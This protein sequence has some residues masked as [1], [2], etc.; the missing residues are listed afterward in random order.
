MGFNI[1]IR[2][3][4]IQILNITNTWQWFPLF[5]VILSPISKR[6]RIPFQ[7][8]SGYRVLTD[9]GPHRKVIFVLLTI[10]VYRKIDG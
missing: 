9:L 5:F 6:I 8:E 7:K 4:K 2:K 10:A 1:K 3:W